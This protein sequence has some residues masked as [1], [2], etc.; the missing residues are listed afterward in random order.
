[1]DV[2]FNHK[3]MKHYYRLGLYDL[4]IIELKRYIDQCI[5]IHQ[6]V[7][8]KY[9]MVGTTQVYYNAFSRFEDMVIGHYSPKHLLYFLGE[10]EEYTAKSKRYAV[11]YAHLAIKGRWPPAEPY[12]IDNPA[13]AAEYAMFIL[14]ERWLKAEKYIKDDMRIYEKY[15]NHF[16]YKALN[17]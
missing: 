16:K 12:I 7:L 1:M 2:A 8:P 4:I 10:L 3:K 6:N 5:K 15:C 11:Y 9:T 13:L 14:K 17:F